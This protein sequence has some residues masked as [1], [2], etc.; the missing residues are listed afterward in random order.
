MF[1]KKQQ[2]TFALRFWRL[3]HWARRLGYITPFKQVASLIV[4]DKA[5]RAS[6]VPVGEEIEVPHHL[7][8]VPL[9]LR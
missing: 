7:L 2:I 5:F 3:T 6:F 9:P 4:S 1:R 8:Q